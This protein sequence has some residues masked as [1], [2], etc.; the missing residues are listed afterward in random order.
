MRRSLERLR[1]LRAAGARIIYGHDPE[2]W[3]SVPQA[4]L[5]V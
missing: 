5:A 2:D 1:A 4:P 3:A